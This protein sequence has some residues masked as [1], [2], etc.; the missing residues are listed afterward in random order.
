MKKPLTLSGPMNLHL[1]VSTMGSDTSLSAVVTDVA[2]DGTSDVITGGS[3]VAS[4]RKV[5]RRKC[6]T[7]TEYCSVYAGGQ[8]IEPWHPYTY[9]SLA[10]ME[11]NSVEQLQLEIFPTTARIQKG[12]RLRVVVMSGDTPHRADTASTVTGKATGGGLDWLWF[13]PGYPS[14]LFLG[15]A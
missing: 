3:L 1:Y 8:I 9:D 12:H 7:R 2:P 15:A 13:G 6:G 11:P 10:P 14:R 5:T 4:L